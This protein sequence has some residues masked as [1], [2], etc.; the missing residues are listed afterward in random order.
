MG[1]E[2][3]PA[4]SLGWR[5]W[6]L[7]EVTVGAGQQGLTLAPPSTGRE[8]RLRERGDGLRPHSEV[9]QDQEGLKWEASTKG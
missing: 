4:H 3:V 7:R 6:G 1:L 8:W 2:I 9:E 5:L